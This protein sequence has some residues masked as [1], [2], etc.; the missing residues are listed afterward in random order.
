[1]QRA[2]CYRATYG[3]PLISYTIQSHEWQEAQ[4][5]NTDQVYIAIACRPFADSSVK[6]FSL[7]D[8]NLH[9]MHCNAVYFSCEHIATAAI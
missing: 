1:M 2:V 5:E 6:P 7:N 3:L 8:M 9:Y 4:T